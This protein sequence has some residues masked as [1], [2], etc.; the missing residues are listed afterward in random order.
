MKI[1]EFGASY[2]AERQD[3]YGRIEG[4][5][6]ADRRVLWFRW[7]EHRCCG[8]KLSPLTSQKRQSDD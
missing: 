7:T 3:Q 4:H 1:I 6:L 2:Y 5:V 8:L